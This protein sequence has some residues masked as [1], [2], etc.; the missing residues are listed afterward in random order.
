MNVNNKDIGMSSFLSS[1]YNTFKTLSEVFKLKYYLLFLV[2]V[3][4]LLA[5][6]YKY[7][8]HEKEYNIST[9]IH[10]NPDLP[11]AL[12][13]GNILYF[14]EYIVASLNADPGNILRNTK[15]SDHLTNEFTELSKRFD[16]TESFFDNYISTI[17]DKE[18]ITESIEEFFHNELLDIESETEQVKHNFIKDKIVK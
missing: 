11:K 3:S 8:I 7:I 5:F 18:N 10:M 16:N 13:V 9:D 2:L 4:L 15:S 1:N 6:S 17:R 14:S 12:S